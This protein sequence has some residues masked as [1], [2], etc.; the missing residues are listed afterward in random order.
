[1][2]KILIICTLSIIL[3]VLSFV[4]G[5]NDYLAKMS[6]S[7]LSLSLTL[8]AIL[9]AI[10][11]LSLGELNKLNKTMSDI[12]QALKEKG[13]D[14]DKSFAKPINELGEIISQ[15]ELD[16]DKT[17]KSGIWI[18][19]FMMLFYISY[20]VVKSRVDCICVQNICS[21]LSNSF[22]CF[23][24]IFFLYSIYDL[25]RLISGIRKL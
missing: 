25:Q 17:I 12:N 10:F 3:G 9:V 23:S 24:I 14:R 5:E 1:M 16:L 13:L 2:K 19:G 18:I 22:I 7:I 8:F 11:T 20:G 4:G 21:I 15:M 6:D